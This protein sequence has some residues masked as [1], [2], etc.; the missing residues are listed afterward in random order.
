MSR[1]RQGGTLEAYTGGNWYKEAM[2]DYDVDPDTNN[3]VFGEPS[4][5]SGEGVYFPSP[6]RGFFEE[7]IPP[8]VMVR[9]EHCGRLHVV[10]LSRVDWLVVAVG[11]ELDGPPCTICS[12]PMPM[13]LAA[14]DGR[15]ALTMGA[16]AR[17]GAAMGEAWRS[18]VSIPFVVL[19][20]A[21]LG[22]IATSFWGWSSFEHYARSVLAGAAFG[23]VVHL[24][25]YAVLRWAVKRRLRRQAAFEAL[26]R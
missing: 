17:L 12:E 5:R 3:G 2:G 10:E 24:C 26:A 18:L 23:V 1:R 22:P 19:F 11:R 4:G 15:H 16:R 25:C 14:E 7:T 20:G 21:L 6:K 8:P 13:L 9:I